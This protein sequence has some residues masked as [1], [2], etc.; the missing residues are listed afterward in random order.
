MHH[1]PRRSL[2]PLP[3]PI[4]PSPSSN[5]RC[6]RTV[7]PV[8]QN[9]C[10]F[11]RKSPASLLQGAWLSGCGHPPFPGQQSWPST[12]AFHGSRMGQ[13]WCFPAAQSPFL[14]QEREAAPSWFPGHLPKAWEGN[15]APGNVEKPVHGLQH[16]QLSLSILALPPRHSIAWPHHLRK[17]GAGA[18]KTPAKLAQQVSPAACSGDML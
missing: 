3:L 10:L 7:T 13:G 2:H 11:P 16:G 5:W 6:S 18:G 15:M 12:T 4:S 8:H 17:E 1:H 9:S 14:A